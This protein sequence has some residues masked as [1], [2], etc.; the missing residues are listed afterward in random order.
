M[1]ITHYTFQSPYSSQ[2]QIGKPD[3]MTLKGDA[4]PPKSTNELLQKAESFE[5]T[6]L[7][8]VTPNVDSK[9]ALDVYV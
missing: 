3:V 1:E 2:I 8:E 5:A 9:D 7:K 4:E 6:Q